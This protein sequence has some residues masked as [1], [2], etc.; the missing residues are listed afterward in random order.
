[1]LTDKFDSKMGTDYLNGKL[2]RDDVTIIHFEKNKSLGR[3]Y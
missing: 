1:M 2:F 3:K